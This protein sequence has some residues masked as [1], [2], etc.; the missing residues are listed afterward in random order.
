[1]TDVSNWRPIYLCRTLYKLYAGYIAGRLTELLVR[2]NVLTPCKKRCLPV[3]LAFEH[4]GIHKNTLE[5]SSTNKSNKCVTWFNITNIFG[6]IPHTALEAVIAGCEIGDIHG[7]IGLHV[8][9]VVVICEG[10][11]RE[12]GI[13]RS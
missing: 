6:L 7:D 4:V 10:E 13:H 5:K 3:D 12:D 1:M 8:L 11:R 9:Q 2:R